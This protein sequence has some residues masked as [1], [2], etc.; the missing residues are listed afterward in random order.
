MIRPTLLVLGAI[1]LA[2]PAFA[3]TQIWECKVERRIEHSKSID[4]TA[5]DRARPEMRLDF[6]VD[7]ADNK[8][9]LLR[10]GAKDR[11]DVLYTGAG[12]DGGVVRLDM[13]SPD[14]MLDLVNIFPK[15]GSFIRIH[16]DMQWM[17]KAGDCNV[18]KGRSVQLP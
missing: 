4:Y 15:T 3:D 18:A 16:G 12:E 11:C 17:G 9:C 1:A 8:G 2:A 10:A 5:A 6:V 7:V 13:K 14:N